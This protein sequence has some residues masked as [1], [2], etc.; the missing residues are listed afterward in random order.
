MAAAWWAGVAKVVAAGKRAAWSAGGSHGMASV[1][2]GGGAPPVDGWRAK[3]AARRVGLTA[4][5]V[6]QGMAAVDTMAMAVCGARRSMEEVD[7]CKHGRVGGV[8]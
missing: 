1:T 7:G 6:I 3:K 4:V 2:A 5:P 8:V